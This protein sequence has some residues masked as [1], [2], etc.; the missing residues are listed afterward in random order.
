MGRWLLLVLTALPL[1]ARAQ[2]AVDYGSIDAYSVPRADGRWPPALAL[3]DSGDG[4]GLRVLSRATDRLM[5]L[6]EYQRLAYGGDATQQLRVGA[7][8]AQPSGTGFFVTLDWH[9]LDRD[10]G[11]A[12]GVHGRVAGAVAGPLSMYGQLGYLGMNTASFHYDGFE[13]TLGLTWDLP[14][15]W[16]VFADYRA[17]LLDDR[18]GVERLHRDELRLGLRFRFDC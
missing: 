17:T 4:F 11:I 15:P 6:G 16:G 1:A 2:D 9:D 13:F 3:G 5:V 7:G 8:L 10:D 14:E 18:D 12:L